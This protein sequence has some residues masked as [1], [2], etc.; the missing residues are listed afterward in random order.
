MFESF[1]LF[2]SP[3]RARGSALSLSL[4]LSPNLAE[5]FNGCAATTSVWAEERERERESEGIYESSLARRV[6][7]RSSSNTIGE[8]KIDM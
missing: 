3:S 2:G 5:S 7:V 8:R 6:P 1:F 4:A